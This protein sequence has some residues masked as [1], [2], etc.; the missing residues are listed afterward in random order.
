MENT[1][2]QRRKMLVANLTIYVK[3]AVNERPIQSLE[4]ILSQMNGIERALVDT[5]DG[6]VKI[7]YNETQVSPEKIKE[8]VL[9]HGLNLED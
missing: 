2:K 5:E 9:Q 3:D 1:N 4:S 8:T 7:E 6:E